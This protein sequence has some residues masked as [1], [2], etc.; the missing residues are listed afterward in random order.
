MECA[1]CPRQ[2]ECTEI[3]EDIEDM[4]PGMGAGTKN[5]VNLRQLIAEKAAVHRILDWEN[6]GELSQG[7][8]EIINLY[9]RR[10]LD[11]NQIAKRLG[12]TQQA[13]SDRLKKMKV[14]LSKLV[15]Q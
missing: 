14:R 5:E 12:I 6:S 1:D 8:R 7:Q 9:Y 10:S 3:C 4:L 2:A 13:V 11:V 15:M